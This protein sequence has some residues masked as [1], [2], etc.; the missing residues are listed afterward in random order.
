MSLLQPTSCFTVLATKMC[1]DPIM[2]IASNGD[3]LQ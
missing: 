3:S 2:P 1:K